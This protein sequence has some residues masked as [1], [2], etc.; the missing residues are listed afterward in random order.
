MQ[1]PRVTLIMKAMGLAPD[2]TSVDPA[3]L[4]AAAKR[5][6]AVHRM[7]DCEQRGIRFRIPPELAGYMGAYHTFIQESGHTPRAIATE[8]VVHHVAW[9][10]LGHLDWLGWHKTRRAILDWK[11]VRSLDEHAV[12]IQLAAYRLA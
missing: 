6:S 10:Y 2:Y 7:I 4:A 12:A 3:V 8:Q 11:C 5:G 9:N 1:R